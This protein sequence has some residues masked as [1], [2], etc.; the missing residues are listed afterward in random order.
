MPKIL[1]SS[2]QFEDSTTEDLSRLFDLDDSVKVGVVGDVDE[3]LVISASANEFGTDIAGKGHNTTIPERSF[4][5]STMDEQSAELEAMAGRL[6]MM[7]LEGK[8]T[9]NDALS[10]LGLFMQ[11][12]IRA[13]IVDLRSPPNKPSTIT[14]KRSDNPLI[15]TGRLLQSISYEVE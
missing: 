10:R 5:R 4:I 14:A 1:T 8:I 6:I 12:K 7:I 15:D 2:I 3:D 11:S 13:K 9:K